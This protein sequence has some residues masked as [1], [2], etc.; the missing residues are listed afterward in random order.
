MF[1]QI[2]EKLLI[3]APRGGWGEYGRNI[4][5]DYLIISMETIQYNPFWKIKI[6]FIV[7]RIDVIVIE[8]ES[9][10]LKNLYLRCREIFKGIKHPLFQLHAS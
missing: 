3:Y 9:F 7:F 10:L 5:I 4:F 1:Y 2:L 6:D 8:A